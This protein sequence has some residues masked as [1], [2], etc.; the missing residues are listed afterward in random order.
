MG[1]TSGSAALMNALPANVEVE[2]M[3]TAKQQ[4]R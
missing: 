3:K 2:A 1:G 4:R